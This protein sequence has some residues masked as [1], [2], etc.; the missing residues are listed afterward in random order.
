MADLN[1]VAGDT[2]PSIFGALTNS[3]GTPFDLTGA[4]VKFQMRLAADRR[5]SVSRSA[6]I[7][8]LATAGSVRYDWQVGDLGTAGDYVSHWLVTFVDNSVEHS[9]PQNTIT[10]EPA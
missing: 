4:T 2:A 1:F 7:V 5:F 3:D 6:V 9:F 10:I 8:G